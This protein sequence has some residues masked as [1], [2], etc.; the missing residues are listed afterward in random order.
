MN[1]PNDYKDK[2]V[3]ILGLAR[4]GR[5]VAELF[6][7][8][9]A[10][11]TA[12]DMK[13]RELCPEADDLEAMGV[14]VICGHH[15]DE[16]IHRDVALVVK[17]PGIP[18]K[19]KPIQ[20][21]LEF[22][23]EI[24]T[25]VE[26]A[27]ALNEG[28]IIA[29]TGSNGKTTTTTWI[30]DMLARAGHEPI[31][32]GNIG[33][34]LCEAVLTAS[35]EQWLVVE[36]SSF[37]LQG[38]SQFRAQI[39]C[40]MNISETH[41]DYHGTMDDYVAAKQKLLEQ[42]GEDDIAIINWDDPICRRMA[43]HTVAN[44]IPFSTKVELGDGL[45]LHDDW[46]VQRDAARSLERRIAPIASI[47]VP[48]TFNI[49]N[50]LAATAVALQVG[51]SIEHIAA[52]LQAFRGVEHRLEFVRSL[53]EVDYFNNSKSTNAISTLR[54]I[55]ALAERPIVLIAGGMDRKATFEEL[56]PIFSERVKA[57]ITIGEAKHILQ[58]IGEKARL[59][60]VQ[61]VDNDNDA[62]RAIDEAVAIAHR[63]AQPGDIVLLSPACASWD[64]F[65]SFEIRGSMFKQA[66]HT[67]K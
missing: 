20:R 59:P 23:I 49:E 6:H 60:H 35:P 1:H 36:L 28:H 12:S 34:P 53:D 30:G 2:H 13:E 44:I 58:Q 55:E 56:I 25:E 11:V 27:Y 22:G 42:Q 66:V 48:G 32:A 50:A 9:G 67:L 40:L 54:A 65:E 37:Q 8:A 64:M 61:R 16:L 3:V 24:V 41:L 10:L 7:R 47:G 45:C 62:L 21:A 18:Y 51:L 46:I 29:I 4:S 26:V 5:A 43:E 38:T 57:L 19:V 14:T 15:P 31:V 39:A 52:S 17:N 63:I 33:T